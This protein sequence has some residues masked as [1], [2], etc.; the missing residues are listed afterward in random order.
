MDQPRR[1]LSE[2]QREYLQPTLAKVTEGF[3]ELRE[4]LIE[5]GWGEGDFSCLVDP[6]GH[7]EFWLEPESGLAFG[8]ARSGCGH[9]FTSHAVF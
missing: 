6:L 5:L 3:T 8:C 1:K 9:G 4:K 7:C 2:D